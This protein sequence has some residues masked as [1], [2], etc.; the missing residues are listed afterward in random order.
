MSQK[1]H[2]EQTVGSN[3]A[4]LYW[5]LTGCCGVLKLYTQVNVIEILEVAIVVAM[6]F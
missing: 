4:L 1:A 2:V 5:E 3:N 6:L